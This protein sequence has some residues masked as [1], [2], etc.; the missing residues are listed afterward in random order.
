MVVNIKL[1]GEVIKERRANIEIDGKP[2]TQKYLADKIGVSQ[3][4]IA[5]LENG[6]K[7]NPTMKTLTKL[8]DALQ[9]YEEEFLRAITG[10]E[11]FEDNIPAGKLEVIYTD[12]EQ[13]IIERFRKLSDTSK[14]AFLVFLD[15]LEHQNNN[16]QAANKE[17]G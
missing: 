8:A 6:K 5:D 13:K 9:V 17:V 10:D 1:L 11:N 7:V 15:Y 14:Q 4:Y 3:G 2:M 12:E 16:E